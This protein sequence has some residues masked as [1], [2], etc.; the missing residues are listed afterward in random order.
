MRRAEG[1]VLL[2]CIDSSVT[3]P[4]RG[5][6][7][8]NKLATRLHA[9]DCGMSS[10]IYPG[11]IPGRSFHTSLTISPTLYWG[12]YKEV[13]RREEVSQPRRAQERRERGLSRR[14]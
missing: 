12:R 1:D 5:H 3:W 11:Y 13:T 7:V 2:C 14:G 6:V 10:G 4:T 8:M 9:R